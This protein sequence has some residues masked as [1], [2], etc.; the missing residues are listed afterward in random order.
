MALIKSSWDSFFSV[1]NAFT[2]LAASERRISSSRC[3]C[4]I[5][6]DFPFSYARFTWAR[7]GAK[8]SSLTSSFRHSSLTK[9]ASSTKRSW[10]RSLICLRTLSISSLVAVSCSCADVRAWERSAA[11]S[12]VISSALRGTAFSSAF[13]TSLST[14]SMDSATFPTSAVYAAFLSSMNFFRSWAFLMRSLEASSSRMTPTATFKSWNLA[15]GTPFL[16]SA[17]RAMIFAAPSFGTANP[18][19]P[20]AYS[21]SSFS[22]KNP[23]LFLSYLSK[24]APRLSILLD[25]V[26]RFTALSPA[27]FAVTLDV[28]ARVKHSA[29]RFCK[30]SNSSL[31]SSTNFFTSSACVERSSAEAGSKRW[32]C[33]STKSRASLQ[34]TLVSAPAAFTTFCK[35]AACA[36]VNAPPS[37]GAAASI[38]LP[39]VASAFST[40]PTSSPSCFLCPSCCSSKACVSSTFL[41]SSRWR[42][43]C[44]AS[45]RCRACSI[46]SAAS[47]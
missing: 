8:R 31:A 36:A 25:A 13:F 7:R 39:Q 45:Q 18:N 29:M 43:S 9:E 34:A 38:S 40:R 30:F 47:C 1:A 24:P 27:A 21:V 17:R 32:R 6:W 4:L 14:S 16:A 22:F 26:S 37:R 42:C 5:R 10:S 19:S 2:A 33:A 11:A 46:C 28:I 15:L 41:S 35:S 12:L 3:S 23:S 20:F 44:T